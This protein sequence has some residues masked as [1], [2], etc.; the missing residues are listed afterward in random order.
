MHNSYLQPHIKANRQENTCYLLSA[1][2]AL[3]L[4]ASSWIGEATC[5]RL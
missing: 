5:T 2:P 3:E 4:G 1:Y